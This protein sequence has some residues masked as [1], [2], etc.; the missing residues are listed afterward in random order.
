MFK[1]FNDIAL[2]ERNKKELED[3]L[4]GINAYNKNSKIIMF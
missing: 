4:N 3:A 2:L 1:F